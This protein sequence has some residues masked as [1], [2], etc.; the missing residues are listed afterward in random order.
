MKITSVEEFVNSIKAGTIHSLKWERPAKVKK[1]CQDE[2][3][4]TVI[5][6]NIM[7][8]SSYDNLKRVRHGREDGSLPEENA[9]IPGFEWVAYPLVLRSVKSG[10]LYLRMETMSNSR[11]QTEWRRNKA[12]VTKAAIEADLLSSEK[13]DSEEL[14]I[15]LNVAIENII[16][17]T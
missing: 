2:I 5:A 17:I 4:K 10:K 1:S 15:V 12:I 6:T 9:G 3:T 13:R 11:F 7:L 14:P 16:D 8:K